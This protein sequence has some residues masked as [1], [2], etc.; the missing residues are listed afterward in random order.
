MANASNF[1]FVTGNV[2][3]IVPVAGTVFILVQGSNAY[4]VVDTNGNAFVSCS[5]S[6]KFARKNAANWIASP[7]SYK[8]CFRKP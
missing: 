3:E 4:S 6:M 2:T 5:P 7:E 1:S 8:A